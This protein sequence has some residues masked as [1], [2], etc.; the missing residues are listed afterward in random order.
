[1]E[2]EIR[3]VTPKEWEMVRVGELSQGETFLYADKG[4][5]EGFRIGI[6]LYHSVSAAWG[7][8]INVRLFGGKNNNPDI[9]H[10]MAPDVTVTPIDITRIDYV[11][12]PDRGEQKGKDPDEGES[13]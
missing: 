8:C 7:N 4:V 3:D 9:C 1:M 12:N 13:K 5:K 6:L 11:R 10:H 2:F